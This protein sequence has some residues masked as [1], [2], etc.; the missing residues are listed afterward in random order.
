METGNGR[1]SQAA[2]QLE[3]VAGTVKR[4]KTRLL[5]TVVL[6]LHPILFAVLLVLYPWKT[7]LSRFVQ[8]SCFWNPWFRKGA[9]LWYVHILLQRWPLRGLLFR[10]FKLFEVLPLPQPAKKIRPAIDRKNPAAEL[11][12]LNTA[13]LFLM[14]SI[15]FLPFPQ[16]LDAGGRSVL[17]SEGTPGLASFYRRL[18]P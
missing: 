18:S 8:A 14:V 11:R 2:S 12:R 4:R 1:F 3:I 13:N 10:P 9:G 16:R 7:A 5:L 15:Y 17:G 6:F